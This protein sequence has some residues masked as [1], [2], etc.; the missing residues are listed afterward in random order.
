MVK[1]RVMASDILRLY[2]P[3]PLPSAL[4]EEPSVDDAAYHLLD[5]ALR[6]CNSTRP[7]ECDSGA[8]L[9]TVI[10][11]GLVCLLLCQYH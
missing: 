6:H 2:F 9:C 5:T 7:R 3:W 4:L 10:F 1:I 11:S 8:L